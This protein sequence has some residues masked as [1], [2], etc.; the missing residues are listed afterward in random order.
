[1]IKNTQEDNRINKA[2]TQ[3]DCLIG[4]KGKEESL[5]H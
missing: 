1:M 4:T 3:G 2:L 5:P